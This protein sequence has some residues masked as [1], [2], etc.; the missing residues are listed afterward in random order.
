MVLAH[1]IAESPRK[2]L[3][4]KSVLI[5]AD[6]EDSQTEL[7]DQLHESGYNTVNSIYSGDRLK[8]IPRQT[9]DAV[10][11]RLSIYVDQANAIADALRNRYAGKNIPLIG[12]FPENHDQ[13]TTNF[14]STL[15]EP[16]FPKQIVHRVAAM[17][18]LS[19]M[20]TE[21]TLRLETLDEDFGIEHKLN[22][23]AFD[24]KLT[25]LFIGKATPEFMII[26]NALERK[27]VEVVAAFTSFS[28]FDFLHDFVFDAVVINALNGM[29]PGLTIAQTMRRNSALYHTPALLLGQKGKIRSQTAFEHGV[30]DIL[31]SDTD[32]RDIQD[33]ILELA[34]FHRLH[35]QVRA[36]FEN[37]GHEAVLD[38]CGTYSGTFFS[39]HLSRLMDTYSTQDLPVSVLTA[40]VC[41]DET[42]TMDEQSKA[43]NELGGIIK[44][45]VRVYDVTARISRN[46][47]VIAFPGQP[48]SS[49]SSV[50]HR[51]SSIPN[52]TKLLDDG[53]SGQ[54]RKIGLNI[55]I[56]EMSHG[57][58]GETWLAQRLTIDNS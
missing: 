44:N 29:E 34:R 2:F 43:L 14:D 33:R 10:I 24:T 28:A 18:R 27:N 50:Q 40:E 38:P 26:I 35:R 30:S 53:P 17:V 15:I 21:I 13:N 32:E 9:P 58:T 51:L 25:V 22:A 57:V 45:L 56:A 23:E 54:S 39:K 12:I 55:D 31:Y 3:A 6:S 20:Q 7:S 36:E 1:S 16:V 4:V 49:L 48:A 19:T 37:M 8:G 11:I 47:F 52:N 46:V 42:V 41:F 5:V